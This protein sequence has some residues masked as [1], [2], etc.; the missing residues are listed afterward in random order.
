MKKIM[1]FVRPDDP[2]LIKIAEAI[3]PSEISSQATRDSIEEMLRVAYGGRLIEA[4][5]YWWV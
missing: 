3:N 5:H 1:K 4:N 2:V